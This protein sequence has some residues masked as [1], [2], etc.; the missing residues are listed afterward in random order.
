[1][2]DRANPF[3]MSSSPSRSPRY[4]GPELLSM[5]ESAL[6]LIEANVSELNRLNVFPVPDGDTGTNMYL[7]VRDI[8]SK[9]GPQASDSVAEISIVMA[10]EA[11]MGGRGNSGVILSHFF[12]G[13]A[14]ALEGC[15]DFGGS[16][17]ARSLVSA[18]VH[19][20]GGVGHPREGTM[21]TVMRETADAVEGQDTDDLALLLGIASEAALA[22]VARTPTLLPVLYRAGLVDAGGYGVYVMLEGMRRHVLRDAELDEQLEPPQPDMGDGNISPD[23]LDEI[24]Q[25]EFG[26][27]TQFLIQGEG[28]DKDSIMAKLLE[29]GASPVVI[30]S[31]EMLR[32]HVHTYKPDDVV[33]YAAS[34][35]SV[36][37][38]NI[39][40]MDEQRQRYSADRRSE[41]AGDNSSVVAVVQGEGLAQIFREQGIENF[42]SGGDT[43]NPSVA[44]LLRAIEDAPTDAV[45]MLPNNPNV[46][47]AAGQAANLSSKRVRVVPSRTVVQGIAAALEYVP[48]G[49]TL[50]ALADSMEG[51]LD[52]VRTGEICLASR[53]ADLGDVSVRDDQV[54]A[55]L[56][57]QLVYAGDSV[58]ETLTG[59]LDKAVTDETELVSL[60]WGE[61]I[62]ERDAERLTELAEE[63]Y[64]DIEFETV[65]GG[66][67]HYH[68]FISIE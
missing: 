62:A 20:Y 23:F 31:E 37:H 32:I 61:P 57:R 18:S 60:Y 13:M 40:D 21:L 15:A 56:D 66:Q 68:F 53:A 48:E 30:G 38:E 33:E 10:R 52:E 36:S 46:A 5:F 1:M 47:L 28:L 25:E 39:Q 51:R 19:A 26:F 6:T 65:Q 58:A 44:D 12:I 16:E 55:M 3:L 41:L 2:K 35:G 54:I 67:P 64:P 50:D 29:V 63:K 4:D 24:E 14:E 45:V 9:S 22:S 8:V 43:M 59:L 17:L 34:L 7:T 42:V 49:L 11:L 27:C